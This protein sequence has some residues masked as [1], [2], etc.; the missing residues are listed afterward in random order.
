MFDN[1]CC[2]IENQV[3][4]ETELP[5]LLQ[6]DVTHPVATH[7]HAKIAPDV[8]YLCEQKMFRKALHLLP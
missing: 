5:A 2:N 3:A 7:F 8:W 1:V 4:R 6:K